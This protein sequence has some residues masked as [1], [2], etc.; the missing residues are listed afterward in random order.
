MCA[1][2]VLGLMGGEG[3]GSGSVDCKPQTHPKLTIIDR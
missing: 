1:E 2:N 3:V